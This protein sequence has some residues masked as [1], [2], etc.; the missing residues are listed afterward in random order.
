MFIMVTATNIGRASRQYTL[1]VKPSPEDKR[2]AVGVC[3]TGRILFIYFEVI[4][5]AFEL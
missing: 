5:S 1:A 4:M 2:P 3:L